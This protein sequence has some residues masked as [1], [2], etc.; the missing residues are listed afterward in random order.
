[1]NTFEWMTSFSQLY[2]LTKARWIGCDWPTK[3]GTAELNLSGVTARQA[4][5]LARATSGQESAD[6]QQAAHWL[7]TVEAD[8]EAARQAA[9]IAQQNAAAGRLQEALAH[10]DRAVML[11]VPYHRQAYWQELKNAILEQLASES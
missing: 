11:E 5:L 10:A 1:M 7:T 2:E 6:W 4:A 8:A 9:E 3:F